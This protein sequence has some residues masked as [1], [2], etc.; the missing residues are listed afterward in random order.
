MYRSDLDLAV[1]TRST[2]RSAM[3]EVA[4]SARTSLDPKPV[5]GLTSTRLSYD[6][7]QMDMGESES[8]RPS[9]A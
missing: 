1:C 7:V 5:P 6:R 3:A 8:S 9:N 4:R 2:V